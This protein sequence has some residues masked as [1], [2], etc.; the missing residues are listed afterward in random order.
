M[1][2]GSISDLLLGPVVQSWL[3]DGAGFIA[4]L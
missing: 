1:V 2:L 4:A 3:P